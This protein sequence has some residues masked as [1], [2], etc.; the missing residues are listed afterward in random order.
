MNFYINQCIQIQY[1][2][3]GA[4]TNSSVLQ[5]GSAGIIKPVSNL[6]N[7]GCYTVPAPEAEALMEE[8]EALT[9]E[10]F[11]PLAAPSGA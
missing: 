2:R 4:V 9:E 10:S 3:I 11:V 6:Y 7:T 8:E 5:I 1:L